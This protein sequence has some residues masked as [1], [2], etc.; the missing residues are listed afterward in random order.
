M[1]ESDCGL[2]FPLMCFSTPLTSHLLCFLV[3]SVK[4]ALELKRVQMECTPQKT[5][6]LDTSPAKVTI[7]TIEGK[8]RIFDDEVVGRGALSAVKKCEVIAPYVP[9]ASYPH[10]KYVVKVIDKKYLLSITNGDLKRAAA[11]VNREVD[12]LRRIPPHPN[13][14]TFIEYIETDELHL[15]FFEEVQCGDLCEIILQT[16]DGKLSEAKSKLYTYQLIKAVLHCHLHDVCHRDIKPENL[17]VSMDD[18]VKL[19]DFGLAKCSLGVCTSAPATDPLSQSALMAPYEGSER[20]AGKE[21]QCFEITG[22]PRYGAP[23]MFYAKFTHT[24]YDG[25]RA[26]AWSIGIVT[27]IILSGRFP[28]CANAG[29]S[30]ND[31][32]RTIMDQQIPQSSSISPVAMSFIEGLLNK[33]PAKRM[34]LDKA[35]QHPWLSEVVVPRKSVIAARIRSNSAELTPE[36]TDACR[37]FDEEAQKYH[38]CITQLQQEIM[39]LT[40]KSSQK[41]DASKTPLSTRR[42]HTPTVTGTPSRTRAS[43]PGYGAGRASAPPTRGSTLGG[44]SAP[45]RS[46]EKISGA[47]GASASYLG[48]NSGGAPLRRATP[49]RTG[50]TPARGV[51]PS[52]GVT[53]AR[54][55]SASPGRTTPAKQTVSTVGSHLYGGAS[56]SRGA[57]P[58]RQ[59]GVSPRQSSVPAPRTTPRRSSVGVSTTSSTTMASKPH[60]LTSKDLVMGEEVLYKGNKAVVRYNGTTGFANGVWIGIEMLEGE[61][62]HDG[63]SYLDKRTYFTCPK[64]KGIFAKAYQLTKIA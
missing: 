49:L 59:S 14:A 52:R 4:A 64:G 38:L 42:A 11:E 51:T 24:H 8:Y 9:P 22:T 36:M 30:E 13:I 3:F 46:S 37:L 34:T 16:E 50:V 15:I 1:S 27:F 56:A 62:A 41:A 35:L 2:L 43:T 57:T 33:D 60:P 10:M 20:L 47:S 26:D 7:T 54:G 53:P 39:K 25:F 12:I 45:F 19:T 29:A 23:E 55:V 63:S 6:D 28:F 21:I 18:S 5:V 31:V 61:G 48:K 32:F 58:S 17:L 40:K 44:S